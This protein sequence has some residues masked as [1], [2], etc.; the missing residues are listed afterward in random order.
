M[1]CVYQHIELQK[2]VSCK[3]LL[4]NRYL[5]TKDGTLYEKFIGGLNT[6]QLTSSLL[7]L[8]LVVS[9]VVVVGS[10]VGGVIVIEP[11]V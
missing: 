3:Q 10:G 2:Y 9:I 1:Y 5:L 11:V 6:K 8:L 4:N 7:L